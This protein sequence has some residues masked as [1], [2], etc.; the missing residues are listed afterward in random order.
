MSSLK[1]SFRLC[2]WWLI[3]NYCDYISTYLHKLTEGQERDA[4]LNSF[5]KAAQVFTELSTSSSPP[6][7]Q[8]VSKYKHLREALW[9]LRNCCAFVGVLS[10]CRRV[11]TAVNVSVCPWGFV[12]FTVPPNTISFHLKRV[13]AEPL[14]SLPLNFCPLLPLYLFHFKMCPSPFRI[15][16]IKRSKLPDSH[17]YFFLSR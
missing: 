14:P 1:P 3:T 17:Q 10:V 11:R 9:C 8:N 2:S 15:W 7:W 5:D 6:R 4:L 12:V 13:I 16:E